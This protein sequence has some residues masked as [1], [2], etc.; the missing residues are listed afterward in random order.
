MNAEW[1]TM[2]KLIA[3]NRMIM[4]SLYAQEARRDAE[5]LE[6]MSAKADLVA[7]LVAQ[8]HRQAA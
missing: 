8:C 6:R 4:N 3:E 7:G 5:A 2:Q 1:G